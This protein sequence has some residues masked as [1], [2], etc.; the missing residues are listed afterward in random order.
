MD[1]L[2]SGFTK[3]LTDQV[4]V[5]G[6]GIMSI[7]T[8]RLTAADL[9]PVTAK[10]STTANR[11]TLIALMIRNPHP[12]QLID[13]AP[14]VTTGSGSSSVPAPT[15]TTQSPNAIHFI[16][17]AADG[18]ANTITSM[19]AGYTTAFTGGQQATGVAWPV[20]PSPGPT[21]APAPSWAQPGAYM[22]LSLALKNAQ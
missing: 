6:G 11:W 8:K 5:Q 7:F 9:G 14:V 22:V 19:P 17:A 12:T 16:I 3:I 13:V 20:I 21:G 4:Y 1:L 15:I 2:T 10:A 18:A